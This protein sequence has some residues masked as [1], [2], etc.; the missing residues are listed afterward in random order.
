MAAL[1]VQAGLARPACSPQSG[2]QDIKL[3]GGLQRLPPWRPTAA[4]A[5]AATATAGTIRPAAWPGRGRRQ[6]ASPSARAAGSSSLDV[7]QD[8]DASA[9]QLLAAAEAVPL[10]ELMAAAAALRD[11]HFCAITFSP[12]VFIP[13][14]RLCRDRCAD[15]LGSQGAHAGCTADQ[16]AAQLTRQL[17]PFACLPPARSACPALLPPTAPAQLRLLHVCHAAHPR[18][19]RLHDAGRGAGGGAPGRA[20]GLHR[21]AVH[22]GWV[23]VGVGEG[24]GMAHG[25]WVECWTW[26]A[27][28]ACSAALLLE[29]WWPGR[30]RQVRFGAPALPSTLASHPTA[31]PAPPARRQAGAGLSRGSRRA[32][33]H[34]LCLDPGVCGGGSGGGA[35]RDRA[36]A[37]C[38]R[39]CAGGAGAQR[40]RCRGWG[41]ALSCS[42]GHLPACHGIL[43]AAAIATRRAQA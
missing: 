9:E 16:L 8:P 21:G 13:L 15:V 2:C 34:G 43:P 17:C 4:A 39:G 5:T 6:A 31:L 19:P 40:P 3:T 22:A 24:G 35:A 41:R 20:A 12:K 28:A 30:W 1:S 26:G 33:S 42:C 11:A 32:G 14:T 38:Q 27:T 37:A 29:P 7:L 25:V 23:R 18:A 36:A 10:P